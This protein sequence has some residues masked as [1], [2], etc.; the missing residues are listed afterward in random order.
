M[1]QDEEDEVK[2]KGT[3]SVPFHLSKKLSSIEGADIIYFIDKTWGLDNGLQTK[4]NFNSVFPTDEDFCE[5]TIPIL[6]IGDE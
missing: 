1:Y 4:M 2:I 5:I 3:P 6:R